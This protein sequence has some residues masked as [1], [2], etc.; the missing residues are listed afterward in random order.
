MTN[1]LVAFAFILLDLV[2]VSAVL[3]LIEVSRF[4]YI[5]QQYD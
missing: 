1:K 5:I 4:G 2:T 3:Y